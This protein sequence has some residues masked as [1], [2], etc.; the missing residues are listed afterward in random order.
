MSVKKD[1]NKMFTI[2]HQVYDTT[3]KPI[4]SKSIFYFIAT[5][6]NKIVNDMDRNR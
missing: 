5:I 3:V 1:F 6:K 4:V 2:R